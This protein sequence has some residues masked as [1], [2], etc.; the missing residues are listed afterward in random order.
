VKLVIAVRASNTSKMHEAKNGTKKSRGT[1]LDAPKPKHSRPFGPTCRME[2]LFIIA[3]LS[4]NYRLPIRP[5]AFFAFTVHATVHAGRQGETICE[6]SRSRRNIDR[7]CSIGKYPMDSI[8]EIKRSCCVVDGQVAFNALLLVDQ[9]YMVDFRKTPS[10]PSQIKLRR[11][12]SSTTK[13]GGLGLVALTR[14]S[15][16]W[17]VKKNEE[18][19]STPH[20]YSWGC[21]CFQT[22]GISTRG[23]PATYTA[24][25]R[26]V[27]FPG[28][29]REWQTPIKP[30]APSLGRCM[31]ISIMQRDP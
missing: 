22:D 1:Y 9:V 10:D 30:S 31:T 24:T 26:V 29:G 21:W 25:S 14:N 8:G 6:H 16:D 18:A 17:E 2:D 15:L 5:M 23:S 4:L 28:I 20:L 19:Q 7:L 11:A 13:S 3:F 27:G 12:A